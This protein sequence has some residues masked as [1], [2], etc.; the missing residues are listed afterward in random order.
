MP[1]KSHGRLISYKVAREQSESTLEPKSF[2]FKGTE[3][4]DLKVKLAEETGLH[5]EEFVVCSRNLFNGKLY[6]LKLHL[7]PN[8]APMN[9]FVVPLS[10]KGI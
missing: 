6:P 10:C 4:E 5:E 7:P 1:A 3:M 9:L 2:H 8:N